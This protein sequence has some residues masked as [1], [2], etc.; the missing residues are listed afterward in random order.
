MCWCAGGPFGLDD[1][2]CVG[3]GCGAEAGGACGWYYYGVLVVDA[4]GD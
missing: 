3:G 4:Y 1:G 2:E